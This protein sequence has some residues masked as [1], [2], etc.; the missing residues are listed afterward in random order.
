[1][2]D[3]INIAIAG[4]TGYIGLELIKILSKHPKSNILYLCARKAIGKTIDHFDKRIN[5][6]GLPNISKIE[7]VNWESIDV[8]FASLPNGE[9]HKIANILPEKTKLID[10]SADF[11]LKDPKVY[12]KWYGIK[13]KSIN[14]IP[15]SIY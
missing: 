10:L 8:L 14:L 1:M 9:A 5:T 13:H 6:K 3:S 15:Q 11:R 2:K 12:K 7:K 4:A